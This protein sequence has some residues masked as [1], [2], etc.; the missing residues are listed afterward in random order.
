M[1][2][3]IATGLS[4]P[5]R[6]LYLI[7]QAFG[8]QGELLCKVLPPWLLLFQQRKCLP[9]AFG[10][11]QRHKCAGRLEHLLS[12]HLSKGFVIPSI[13]WSSSTINCHCQILISH[14]F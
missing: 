12:E 10:P 11:L 2:L 5:V 14:L 6:G 1:I 7:S 3:G 4:L 13:F 8:D 9:V